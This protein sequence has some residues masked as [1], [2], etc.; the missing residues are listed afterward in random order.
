MPLAF[1][2][3]ALLVLVAVGLLL[4]TEMSALPGVGQPGR[5]NRIGAKCEA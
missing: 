5:N 4:L 1:I 2:L 3:F